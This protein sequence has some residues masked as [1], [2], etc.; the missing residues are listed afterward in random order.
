V[1]VV[2]GIPL[3]LLVVAAALLLVQVIRLKEAVQWLE[4]SEEAIALCVKTERNLRAEQAARAKQWLTGKEE[5][6][7]MA[8]ASEF[9]MSLR[10]LRKHFVDSDPGLE[11]LAA[12]ETSYRAWRR[13]TTQVQVAP[14]SR[15]EDSIQ[16]SDRLVEEAIA[17][18]RILEREERRARVVRAEHVDAMMALL[19]YAALP[20]LLLLALAISVNA[21]REVFRLAKDFNEAMAGWQR[22]NRELEL[23]GWV[24]EQLQVL[25]VSRED[26][27]FAS[28]AE[29]AL[30]A[31]VQATNAVVG[32]VHVVADGW[33]ERC[34][35]HG[36][37][38]SSSE[39]MRVGDGL[40]GEA[41]RTGKLR[42][43]DS[44]PSG[45]LEVASSL[46]SSAATHLAL[47][48]CDD[49]GEINAV[50]ELGFLEAPSERARLLLEHA[51]SALGM[52]F[53]V[54]SKKVRLQ[55]LLTESRRQ[56]EA[57]QLQQEELR[58]ANEELSSQSEALKAA[59]TQLEA[60]KAELERSNLELT[61]QRNALDETRKQL[62][63]RAV[64]LRRADRYKSEFLA[65]MSHELRTPLNSILILS[66]SLSQ[67]DPTRLTPEEIRYAE[68][69]HASGTDLLALINDVLELSKLEAGALELNLSE[70]TVAEVVRPVL[71]VAEPLARDRGLELEA[72]HENPELSFTTDVRRVQQILKNL[73]SNACKF[74][75]HGKVTFRSKRRDGAVV[76][77]VEDTGLGIAE[78][79]LESVFEAFRQVDANAN[80]RFGGTGLGLSISR[81]L[82]RNLG[83]DV[84]V[85]SELGRGSCFSVTLPLTPPP[86]TERPVSSEPDTPRSDRRRV[87]TPPGGRP[88]AL[89]RLLVLAE[90]ALFEQLDGVAMPL[91]FHC[92]LGA[93]VAE[94]ISL[95][96]EEHPAAIIV[97]LGA[98]SA[99]EIEALKMLRENPRTKNVP[100]HVMGRPQEQEEALSLGAV[101]YL[102]KPVL[103]DS[104]RAALQSLKPDSNGVWRVLVVEA[105]PD[106]AKELERL[107]TA[108]D[109]DTV[110]VNTAALA[111]SKLR[112]G[113]FTC[114]ITDLDLPDA[115]G[116]ELL[117][118]LRAA[119]GVSAPHVIV[120]TARD[121]SEHEEQELMR[122]SDAIILKGPRSLERVLDEV[123][124]FLHRVNQVS[125]PTRSRP[126][127]TR[128][129][130]TEQQ[131]LGRKLLL[132]EDDVRSVFTLTSVLERQGAELQV[133]RNGRVALQMLHDGVDV[134]LILMDLMMPEMDGLEA[135]RRIRQMPGRVAKLP[136]IALTAKAMPDIRDECIRSGANDYVSKPIELDKLVSLIRIWLSR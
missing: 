46:G 48:P 41:A 26:T 114:L 52:A 90:P 29:R 21:R 103:E 72:Q 65:S 12:V 80:R 76:F 112:E 39:T 88:D 67:A 81:D 9:A 121:I 45:Y 136:I 27:G 59:H 69:I 53:A 32:S 133:A 60:R 40:L 101:S 85:T 42:Y 118:T 38:S 86:R 30:D 19:T 63:T 122:Y 89:R 66:K 50:V 113:S 135:T 31:L 47:L 13:Y 102:K 68:T 107:L 2:A 84:T 78:E 75:A 132:V 79:H 58:V 44:L 16:S 24:R 28:L 104:L 18:I 119:D 91:G 123:T 61:N 1:W 116:H 129:R 51:G 74:T 117:R 105:N 87:D 96:G 120:H 37:A 110:L 14:D 108:S 92:V 125:P 111:M 11:Q 34:A 100:L 6:D 131:L 73:L 20:T 115:P 124:L 7:A 17:A 99:S 25:A 4:H 126:R 83:G 71:R 127:P 106:H 23:Q 57:L 77:E 97:D 10:D 94:V 93:N 130:S 128:V 36:I 56:A 70:T 3:L 8:A 54:T 134:E 33:L 95:A 49:K 82:A 22:A 35:G 5:G 43:V 55:E 62:E 109:V 98:E 15:F 64:Q